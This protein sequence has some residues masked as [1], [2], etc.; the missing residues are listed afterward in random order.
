MLPLIAALALFA[1]ACGD[2]DDGP[3]DTTPPPA[4]TT[5]QPDPKP[6]TKPPS[7]ERRGVV[8]SLDRDSAAPG[9][10]LELTID[11][12]TSMRL[13]YGVAYRLERRTADGWRW[14]NRDAAFILILKTIEPGHRDREEIQ[15]P[16]DLEPGR[17]RIVKEFEDPAA[18]ET[19]RGTVQ[20]TVR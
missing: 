16:D 9:E 4:D 5:S 12:R 15:L 10:T 13:E 1:G 8:L 18:H 11:N 7:E 2:D 14:V 17:Y 19:L 6:E 20:F 3:V